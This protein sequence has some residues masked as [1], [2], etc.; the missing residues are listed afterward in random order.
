MC[1]T[2]FLRYGRPHGF[3]FNSLKTNK[4]YYIFGG[5][6]GI[7]P[8]VTLSSKHAFQ[9]CAFSHS[10]ISPAK[11]RGTTFRKALSTSWGEIAPSQLGF[12]LWARARQRKFG[13]RGRN[14]RIKKKKEELNKKH[15]R[16]HSRLSQRLCAARK[17][18][19]E[20][21]ESPSSPRN[22]SRR[23]PQKRLQR[24]H[25]PSRQDPQFPSHPVQ[26]GPAAVSRHPQRDGSDNRAPARGDRQLQACHKPC[27]NS[28][29]PP[30]R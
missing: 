24:R 7:R 17:V 28:F 9:A 13:G 16:E 5:E 21:S 18:L 12:I 8:H 15:R 27:A 25:S 29:L 23:H 2:V 30:A 10:A 26:S 19:P 11:P 3:L 6:S 22:R 20:D 14:R 1:G 4:L